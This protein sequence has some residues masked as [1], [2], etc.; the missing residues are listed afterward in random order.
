VSAKRFIGVIEVS[1]T[2]AKFVVVDLDK[3]T[4]VATRRMPNKVVVDGPYPH[5]DVEGLWRFFKKAIAEL[6]REHPL[7][8]LSVTT[9]GACAAL[10]DEAGELALPVLDYEYAGP[11]SCDADYALVRPDFTESFTP[12]LPGGLNLGKQLFWQQR[13]FPREFARTQWVVP[14]PQYWSFRLTGV[15]S[16]EITSLGCHTD[17]WNFETD[18]YSS[19]VLAQGWIGK[20]PEVKPA[21]EP[22]GPVQPELAQ[23]LGLRP[24]LPVYSGIHNINASLLPHILSREPPFA[25]VSTG[26]WV[27]VAAPGGDLAHLDPTRDCLANIDALGHPVPSARFMGGREFALLTGGAAIEPTAATIA[28]VLERGIFLLPSVVEG[29]GPYPQRKARWSHARETLDAETVY[30]TASFYLAMM[31]AEC[32]ALAGAEGDIVV[33]GPFAGN[34]AFLAMLE[35]AACRPVI[36]SLTSTAGR[37]IGAAMLARMEPGTPP[38]PVA[39]NADPEMMRYAWRWRQALGV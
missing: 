11:D 12:P 24:G 39:L 8:A 21:A 25:V 34:K 17:L 33:E 28:R 15:V 9:H 23:E 37:A 5:F 35:A 7:D 32:L 29:S 6:N 3:R 30:V 16:A 31:T 20:M 38:P 22:L 27:I 13:E 1:K 10:I 2:N 36:A 4:E 19:L 14:Y 18:L 26:T